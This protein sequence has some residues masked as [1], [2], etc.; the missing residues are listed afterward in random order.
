MVGALLVAPPAARASACSGGWDWMP[1]TPGKVA[2]A[3]ERGH[4]ALYAL[5]ASESAVYEQALKRV[6]D[7]VLGPPHLNPPLGTDLRGWLRQ[8]PAAACGSQRP[9]RGVP[10]AGQGALRYHYLLNVDGTPQP[11]IETAIAADWAVN[12]LDAVFSHD[13]VSQ[14]TDAGPFHAQPQLWGHLDGVPVYTSFGRGTLSLVFARGQ[15]AL[16]RPVSNEQALRAAI[17]RL[18]AEVKA[19]KPA[20]TAPAAAL[21]AQWLADAAQR[22][23]QTEATLD[24]VRRGNPAGAEALRQNMERMNA[25]MGESFRRD[26]ERE[27]ARLA[28]QAGRPPQAQPLTVHGVLQRHQDWLARLSPEQRAAQAVA[29]SAELPDPSLAIVQ[30]DAADFAE[31]LRT[32]GRALVQ[33]DPAYFD[34]KLPR[35]AL[36]LVVFRT[37]IRLLDPLKPNECGEINP[38]LKALWQTVHTTPWSR[39]QRLL[40]P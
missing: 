18:Q 16:W 27:Q 15:R 22:Q 38:G 3:V 7:V 5:G 23:R 29:L 21:Y 24:A 14:D 26:A 11:I 17:T 2:V 10:V 33:A 20:A 34:P 12:E 35:T 25:E 8:W 4:A 13:V 28:Q 40:A 31:R 30:E 19:F 39:I 32:E 36:Q 37:G 9:C 6:L 1:D